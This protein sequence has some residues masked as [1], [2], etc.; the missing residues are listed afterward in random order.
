MTSILVVCPPDGYEGLKEQIIATGEPGNCVYQVL[1][2]SQYGCAGGGGGGGGGV[3]V[4]W[5]LI[6]M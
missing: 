5:I 6:L 3:N 4:G 1:F 2:V